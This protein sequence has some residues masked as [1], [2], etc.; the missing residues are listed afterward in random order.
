MATGLV[1][2]VL[3]VFSCCFSYGSPSWLG[4][5]MAE[6][7]GKTGLP[8]NFG[9]IDFWQ[10]ARGSVS[11]DRAWRTGVGEQIRKKSRNSVSNFHR[12]FM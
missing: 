6:K 3:Y 5:Q 4:R 12:G 8:S 11:L 2:K 9:P 7:T 10:D 1:V